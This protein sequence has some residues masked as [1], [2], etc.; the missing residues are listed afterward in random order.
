MGQRIA[1]PT[2]NLVIVDESGNAAWLP[3]GAVME[4]QQASFT[5]IKEQEAV[6]TPP[7]R[8]LKLP[9]VLNPDMGRIWTANARVISADDF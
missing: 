2:Q 5:A 6:N 7:K 1:I 3:G 8:A 4:R 9:M